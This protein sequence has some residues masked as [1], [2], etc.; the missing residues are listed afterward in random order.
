MAAE[1]STS[2]SDMPLTR[3]TAEQFKKLV[4]S[5]RA[6]NA[7]TFVVQRLDLKEADLS[8]QDL[9]NVSFHHCYLGEAKL[10]GAKVDR[11]HFTNCI[12]D[13]ADFSKADLVRTVFIGNTYLVTQFNEANIEAAVF[14]NERFRHTSFIGVKAT[15]ASF[16]NATLHDADFS[17]AELIRTLFHNA[18][19]SSAEFSDAVLDRTVFIRADLSDNPK[20]NRAR[21]SYVHFDGASSVAPFFINATIRNTKLSNSAM[22]QDGT[23]TNAVLDMDGMCIT[24]IPDIREQVWAKVQEADA[25]MKQKDDYR[26][27]IVMAAWHTCGTVHCLGGW[28][29]EVHPQGKLLEAIFGSST[30]ASFILAACGVPIP[31]FFDTQATTGATERAINWL[32]TGKQETPPH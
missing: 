21:L 3:T 6:K 25:A 23:F 29:C 17:R 18:K 22:F 9:S 27:P 7:N 2:V 31:N 12:L 5:H 8:G 16:T 15:G 4:A 24:R 10:C 14:D 1:T 30:A 28:I 13:H 20:L 19:F 32:K 11:S 26:G